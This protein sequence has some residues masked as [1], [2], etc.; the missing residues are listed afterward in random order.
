MSRTGW[1]QARRME[2]FEDVLGRFDA[3]RLSAM[4]AAEL[5]GMSERT[6]RR[7]RRRWDEDGLEGLFGRRLGKA[8][9]R[10]VLD[11][12]VAWVLEQYRNRH[13]GW[14]VKH[15]H[16]HLCARHG[17]AFSYNWTRAALQRA[18]LVSRAPPPASAQA[19]RRHDAAPEPASAKAG[20][21]SRYEWLAGQPPLDLIVTLDDATSEIYSA[22]LVAEEGTAST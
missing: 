11:D 21:G 20:D 16:D 8:C 13:M 5:L 9:S 10:R 14:T 18:G 15:F 22:F 17:F 6:F 7:Y 2:K 1:L 12:R 4:D 19:L 3:K